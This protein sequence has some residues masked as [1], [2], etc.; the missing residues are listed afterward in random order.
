[1]R[2]DYLLDPITNDLLIQG[3]DFVVG[4][5]DNQHI[6]D[7]IQSF[8]GEYKE[9]PFTG[10]GI[11]TSLNASEAQ[12]SINRVRAQLQAGGYSLDLLDI[13]IDESG[14]L[15]IRFPEGIFTNNA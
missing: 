1:M 8:Q 7:I 10:A 13:G 12:G 9:S 5:S 15:F 14:K 3:G 2:T 6:E 4:P 11:L